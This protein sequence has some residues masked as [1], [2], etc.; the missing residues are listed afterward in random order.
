LIIVRS[1]MH[2]QFSRLIADYQMALRSV[3]MKSRRNSSSSWLAKV[4]A[5]VHTSIS[6][7]VSKSD[8]S[9]TSLRYL[10]RSQTQRTHNS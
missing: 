5:C 3:K 8:L 4:T 7:I 1:R 10:R 2:N 9:I 6:R